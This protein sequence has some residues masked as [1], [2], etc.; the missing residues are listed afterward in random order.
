MAVCAGAGMAELFRELGVDRIVTG[1]QTMNPSTEDIVEAVCATPSEVVF[2][3]P[4]NKNIYM[5]AKQAEE[6]VTDKKVVVLHTVSIPQG[7][8]AMLAF[9]PDRI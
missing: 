5:S 1:G 9:D 3:L 7:I 6:I 2:V 4:N 8:S